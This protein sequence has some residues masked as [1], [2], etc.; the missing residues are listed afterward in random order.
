MTDTV[1]LLLVDDHPANLDVLEAILEA[2]DR[3]LVR[4]QSAQEALLALLNDDFAAIVLDIQM[5]E[6]GGIELAQLI[7]QRRRTR[8]IPILFL[9]AFRVEERDILTGY[10]AG[11]VDYLTK[12]V[13]PE[14]LRFKMAVFV[15]LFRKTRALAASNEALSE[16][17]AERARAQAALRQANE[18]LEQRVVQRTIELERAVAN[19]RAA[20][21]Q[22]EH[23]SKLKEDFL[24]I[25]SHELR[26]P[27]NAI[28]G[29]VNILRSDPTRPGLLDKGL[30][31]IDRNARSQAQLIEDLL[32]MSSIASGKARLECHEVRLMEV[33]EAALYSVRPA[34]RSD[35]GP[36]VEMQWRPSGDVFRDTA[37][38][39]DGRRL[40]QVFANLLSNA[41]AFTPPDGRVT[42]EGRLDDQRIEIVVRDTGEG[43]SPDFLPHLFDKFRQADGSSTRRHRGL[44]LGLAIVKNLV[45]LHGGEVSGH[46]EGPGTGSAFTVMLP[47]VSVAE[48][49]QAKQAREDAARRDGRQQARS[50]GVGA[51]ADDGSA[52]R[53]APATLAGVRVLAV[54][55]EPDAR[56]TLGE[57]L[58]RLEAK[59][60]TAAS[61]R[62]ALA[63]M[64][65]A[66]FDLLIS[67]IGMPGEDGYALIR[68]VR[69]REAA[70]AA[71]LPAI[72]CTAFAREDDRCRSLREGYDDHLSKPVEP[73][74]LAEVVGDLLT[75]A[76]G[77]SRSGDAVAK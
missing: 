17:M 32:D 13:N 16:E 27:L 72:A 29:W 2:P 71:R 34:E 11:A 66:P 65:K 10:G 20:R 77:T 42:V 18:E 36:T 3:R 55:D 51:Q 52:R 30:T 73:A 63:S 76:A 40:Q 37:I 74:R 23:E 45:Q 54:D 44:G 28:Y 12:P 58:T 41:L 14:I 64:E 75:R 15:E 21:A 38:W 46:S 25:V 7:K 35:A 8:D 49:M 61:A 56:E 62:E 1:N 39:A 6:I 59:V 33:I 9:T 26:T 19:E 43:I 48:G 31:I 24:A 67:D 69:E 70:G 57:L 22:A 53:P 47:R 5:P 50:A 68:R 60:T 4:A